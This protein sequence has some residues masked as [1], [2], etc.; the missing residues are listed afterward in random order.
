MRQGAAC[1]H[2]RRNRPDEK[3]PFIL[4]FNANLQTIPRYLRFHYVDLSAINY[5]NGD[6]PSFQ[7]LLKQFVPAFSG[8]ILNYESK[9]SVDGGAAAARNNAIYLDFVTNYILPLA[10]NAGVYEP[11]C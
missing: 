11:I 9:S 8:C 5:I 7:P 3:K 2:K 4:A 10:P 1:K 6:F